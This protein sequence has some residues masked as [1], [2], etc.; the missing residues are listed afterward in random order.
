MSGDLTKKC[1]TH[2]LVWFMQEVFWDSQCTL[3]KLFFLKLL[4]IKYSL[5]QYP[6]TDSNWGSTQT[7]SYVQR[8]NEERFGSK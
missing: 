5:Q 1:F 7:H 8:A 3:I 4:D 2:L 6:S